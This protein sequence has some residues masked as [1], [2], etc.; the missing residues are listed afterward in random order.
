MTHLPT[1]H[2]SKQEVDMGQV[3]YVPVILTSIKTISEAFGVSPATIK[4]WINDGAPI[5]VQGDESHR[6]YIAELADLYLW[7]R[8]RAFG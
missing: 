6:R 2:I 3:A 7:L 1:K 8:N 4:R 5:I